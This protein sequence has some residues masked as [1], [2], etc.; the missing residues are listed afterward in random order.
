MRGRE[1]LIE[2]GKRAVLTGNYDEAVGSLTRAL[3]EHPDYAD[4]HN[5]LGVALHFTGRSQEAIEQFHRAIDLNPHYTEAHVNLALVLAELGR[6]DEA[7]AAFRRAAESEGS[8]KDG[9]LPRGARAA[10]ANRHAELGDLYA[11]HGRLEEAAGEYRRALALESGFHDLRTRLGRVLLDAG[12]ATLAASEFAKV[13]A[14]KPDDLPALLGLGLAYERRG[15]RDLARAVW[16]RCR[17]LDPSDPAAR[18][19]LEWFAGAA[20]GAGPGAG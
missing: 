10:L 17:E 19:Y 5:F 14:E 15:E 8:Q 16:E 1:H 20:A 11:G 3:A 2:R 13:A 7:E 12:R 18:V 6:L 4:L 9:E